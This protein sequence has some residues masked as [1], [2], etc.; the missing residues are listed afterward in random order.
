MT[1]TLADRRTAHV[2]PISG[3]RMW[4]K[5]APAD[6]ARSLAAHQVLRGKSEN[7]GAISND[8]Q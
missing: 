5:P 1:L 8:R 3:A 7:L 2:L 6:P 4:M